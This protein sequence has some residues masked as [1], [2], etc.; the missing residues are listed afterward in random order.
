MVKS[1]RLKNV[2]PS[3]K[4]IAAQGWIK[5]YMERNLEHGFIGNLDLL[6]EDLIIK[7]DIYG[8]DRRGIDTEIPDLGVLEKEEQS[9]SQYAWWNSETQSNWLD[10]FYRTSVMTGNEKM[11]KKAEYYL[12]KRLKTQDEDGY[13][14][15]YRKELRYQQG[16]EN[17]E[18]WAQSS[19]A[20]ALL[21]YYQYTKNPE[22]LER[23]IRALDLTMENYPKGMSRPFSTEEEK[24]DTCC[25]GLSHG[26]TITDA[27]LELYRITGEE[28]YLD[29]CV[30]LYESYSQESNLEYDITM[31]NLQAENITFQSHG[32]H[33]YEHIRALVI[34]AYTTGDKEL[35]N[36]CLDKLEEYLSPSGGPI[37]DEWIFPGGADP[38]LT[39]YEY[40]SIH[41]LLH[42]YCLLMQVTGELKWADK[43]EWLFFNAGRGSHHP[44][45]SSIAYLKSDNSY[46]MKSAFQM[47]QPHC[48]VSTQTRYKYSPVHQDVAVCCVPNAGRI[49]PYYLQNMWQKK[50]SGFVKMLYGPSLLQ[51]EYKGV[52]VQIQENSE[53][54]NGNCIQIKVTAAGE[55]SFH[56][57]L[58]R[59]SW[60]TEVSVEGADYR[61]EN[62]FLVLDGMWSGEREIKIIYRQEL[63]ICSWKEQEYYFSYGPNVLAF[64]I[65]SV[66]TVKKK[67]SV[68][69]FEDTEYIPKDQQFWDYR[70]SGELGSRLEI[71]MLQEGIPLWNPRT[72]KEELC[73]LVPMGET[74]LRKVT[75]L[76]KEEK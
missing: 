16:K 10:G 26:L 35:L 70:V 9:E 51:T 28:K 20:R 15:I 5:T 58:R 7:D 24:P 23:T 48:N 55:I 13:L 44:V 18:L 31:P 27:Y 62:G 49:F 65:D 21:G 45:E 25:C 30:F 67:Y 59:P 53:Y 3:V 57:F 8:K 43:I 29:Y 66:R 64:P 56:I 4:E 50:E 1:E 14:G 22:V 63:K 52:P 76:K 17:G 74:I 75:F 60:W 2:L 37:G 72:E 68:E 47:P 33:T 36:R 11:I 73:N 69:G 46:S 54:P 42:S 6:A 12:E 34:Y 19:L 38:S 39:G 40:C 71:N 41:E 32:V 61:E